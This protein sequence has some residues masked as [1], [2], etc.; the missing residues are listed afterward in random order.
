MSDPARD[1][2]PPTSSSSAVTICALSDG[3]SKYIWYGDEG[4]EFLFDQQND[5]RDCHDLSAAPA[6]QETLAK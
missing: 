1:L 3:R 5:L 6:W 4:I 2:A